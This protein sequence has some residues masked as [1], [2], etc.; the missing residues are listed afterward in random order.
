MAS[1]REQAKTGFHVIM[2]LTACLVNNISYRTD[3]YNESVVVVFCLVL[4]RANR[5]RTCCTWRVQNSS[6]K[7]TQKYIKL[8]KTN[9]TLVKQEKKENILRTDFQ[10]FPMNTIR[11]VRSFSSNIHIFILVKIS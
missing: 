10:V 7:R 5:V 4:L 2:F 8:F 3:V 6:L 1:C 9:A 11:N